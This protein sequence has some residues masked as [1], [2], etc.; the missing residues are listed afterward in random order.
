MSEVLLEARN[1][2]KTFPAD[3]HRSVQAVSGVSLE[4]QEGTTLGLVGESGCGKSTLGRLMMHLIPPDSGEIL[5]R[6]IP[7]T[8]LSERDFM[9]YRRML[10]MVFQ[11]PYASLNPRMNVRNLIAEPLETYRMYETEEETT[12]HV[13][14]LMKTVGLPEGYL[15]RYPHQFSGGQRQRIAIARAIAPDPDLIVCDEPVS[16]LDVSVQNQILNLL[17]KLQHTRGLTY[18]FISHDLSVI[19]Y[20]SDRIAVMYLGKICE[21]GPTEEV[22]RE[23]LHPSAAG[24]SPA[25]R[26]TAD[27]HRGNPKPAVA[28]GRMPVSYPVPVRD[29]KMRRGGTGASAVRGTAGCMPYGNMIVS[30]GLAGRGEGP[31]VPTGYRLKIIY[32][33]RPDPS[34]SPDRR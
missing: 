19:R 33:D 29:E 26:K 28:A 27:A 3:R 31:P 11:D 15:Y 30:D 16:A 25:R 5:I 10:Q 17:K 12:R 13:L 7:V 24:S 14:E 21:T 22:F 34:R 18:L 23:P 20:I 6:G 4:L 9:K 1:L 32:K 2:F 8:G